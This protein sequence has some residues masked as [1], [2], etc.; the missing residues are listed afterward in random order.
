MTSRDVA[1][2]GAPCW[3]DLI[4]SDVAGR[5][6]ASYLARATRPCS[7]VASS[8]AK[9]PASTIAW[10]APFEPTGYMG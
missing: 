7:L 9:A 3:V 4:T 1:P 2:L 5:L 6:S 8:V 10:L